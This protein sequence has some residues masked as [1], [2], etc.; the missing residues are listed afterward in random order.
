MYP[1]RYPNPQTISKTVFLSLL[2]F[3][4]INIISQKSKNKFFP[5]GA[6]RSFLTGWYLISDVIPAITDKRRRRHGIMNPKDKIVS[7][8]P[9][10]D[11]VLKIRIRFEVTYPYVFCRI[12]GYLLAKKRTYIDFV[13]YSE[14]FSRIKKGLFEEN[15]YFKNG[16]SV[17]KSTGICFSDVNCRI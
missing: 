6:G 9:I 14:E 5:K 4:Y 16:W 11:L 12:K 17:I 8:N 3:C 7:P 15:R 1:N 2:C 13:F 10:R